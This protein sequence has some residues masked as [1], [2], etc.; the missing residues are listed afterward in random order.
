LV[1]EVHVLISYSWFGGR[2]LSVGGSNF[3]NH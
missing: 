3:Y 1:G 2:Y